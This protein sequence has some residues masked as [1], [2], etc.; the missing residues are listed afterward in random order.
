MQFFHC[1]ISGNMF[2]EKYSHS[3]D[4]IL[5]AHFFSWCFSMQSYVSKVMEELRIYLFYHSFRQ[6]HFK[7]I[8]E[9]ANQPF[10]VFTA[11]YNNSSQFSEEADGL[12]GGHASHLPSHL[13]NSMAPDVDFF[14]PYGFWEFLEISLK[15]ISA[16][17]C[18]FIQFLSA[19]VGKCVL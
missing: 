2:L 12:T 13:L 5:F 15:S 1:H 6:E 11:C 19:G 3:N 4:Q 10:L 8:P 16:Q 9:K 17:F 18:F 7:T 14:Q